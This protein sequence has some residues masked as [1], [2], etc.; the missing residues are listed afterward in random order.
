[1]YL[2]FLSNASEQKCRTKE[3]VSGMVIEDLSIAQVGET[4]LQQ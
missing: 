2:A 3:H 4:H 1:M